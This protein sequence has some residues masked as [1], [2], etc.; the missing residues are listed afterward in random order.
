[1]KAAE[2]RRIQ[3]EDALKE[4]IQA[5]QALAD[6]VRQR[7]FFFA[8]F[9]FLFFY[10]VIIHRTH[11]YLL[12]YSS[13]MSNRPAGA[14]PCRE[15]GELNK[16]ARFWATSALDEGKGK[17]T[18]NKTELGNIYNRF[19]LRRFFSLSFCPCWK[20]PLSLFAYD[21]R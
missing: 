3:L 1:M 19:Y 14:R 2:Q 6:Q 20:Q 12:L 7:T 18:T 4:K 16:I 9:I 10:L 15:L 17:T 11:S 8:L 21:P 13:L 5:K